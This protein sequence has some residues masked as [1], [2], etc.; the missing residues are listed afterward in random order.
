[1]TSRTRL[2]CTLLVFLSVIINAVGECSTD[3]VDVEGRPCAWL[4]GHRER[5]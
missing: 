4:A 5:F 2:C 3:H 1:M